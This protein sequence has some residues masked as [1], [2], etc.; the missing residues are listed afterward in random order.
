MISVT[1]FLF[2][3]EL[4]LALASVDN[5]NMAAVFVRSCL[6][7]DLRPVLH[8]DLLLRERPLEAQRS[9]VE[10]FFIKETRQRPQ[11]ESESLES[12]EDEAEEDE[13]ESE[14]ELLPLRRDD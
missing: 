12:D 4:Q 3:H 5:H 8:T 11:L 2:L 7:F 9:A 13:E 14:L 1:V 6:E 10:V